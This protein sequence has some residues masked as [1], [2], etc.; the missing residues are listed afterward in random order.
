MAREQGDELGDEVTYV[1][2]DHPEFGDRPAY[3]PT[4][5]VN[6]EARGWVR[7]DTKR[8]KTEGKAAPAKAAE[9]G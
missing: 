2:P 6:L 9:N 7:K 3:T 5:V 8:A 4:D 1:N